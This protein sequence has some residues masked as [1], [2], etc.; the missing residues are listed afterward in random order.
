MPR[1]VLPLT[2]AAIRNAKPRDKIFT[3]SDGDGLYL[4]ILPSGGRS[5]R[6]KYRFAG[7]EKRL[8]FGLWPDV[9]LKQAR[10]MR[11]DARALVAKGVDPRQKQK[12]EDAEAEVRAIEAANTFEVIARDWHGQQVRTWSEDH[13]GK[14]MLRL[15]KHLFPVIGMVPVTELR[16][17]AILPVLRE[18]EA[19]GNNETAKRLRQYCEAVFAFAIATGRAERNVGADLRGALVPSKVKNR[20]AITDPKRFGA[21][22][23]TI[24]SYMGSPV[25]LAGLRLLPLVFVRPGE[26]RQAEWTEIDLDA[27]DGPTWSIPAEKMKMRRDH[28]VPLSR[29][30]VEIIA[31]LHPLTGAGRY[32]FPC[33]RTN[34][35]PMSNMTLNAALRRLDIAQDEH[36]AHGFRSSASTML[37]EMGF[38]SHIIEAQLAHAERNAVKAAYCRAEYLPERRRMMQRWADFCDALKAGGRVTPLRRVNQE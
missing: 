32:L 34:G 26:L 18:I 36:C 9:S 4:A 19:R 13:A 3:L 1:K 30:A 15:E 16:A 23:R 22:L 5:W 37:H 10:E 38:P 7:Q 24:E 17:P 25:T 6:F 8:V 11:D 12:S 20:P 35:R 31:D 21:L 14:V 27:P 33:N 29:Q 28:V 2:D